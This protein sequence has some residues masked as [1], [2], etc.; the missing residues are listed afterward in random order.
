MESE[1]SHYIAATS[2]L[3]RIPTGLSLFDVLEC[4]MVTCG[5]LGRL[6]IG[7]GAQSP[8]GLREPESTRALILIGDGNH[9]KLERLAVRFPVDTGLNPHRGWKLIRFVI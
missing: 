5:K 2:R 8:T 3:C 7:S 4:F 6:E 9:E 1:K